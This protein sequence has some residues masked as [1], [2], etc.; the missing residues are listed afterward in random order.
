[1]HLSYQNLFSLEEEET[2]TGRQPD[3]EEV[4]WLSHVLAPW[5]DQRSVLFDVF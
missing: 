5:V 3:K 1:M 4:T 2:K